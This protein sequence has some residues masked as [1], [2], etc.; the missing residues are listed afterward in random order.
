MQ[1]SAHAI[2]RLIEFGFSFINFGTVAGQRCYIR[3]CPAIFGTVGN[4]A[5]NMWQN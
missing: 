1:V 3:D 4:Y 5:K 2:A